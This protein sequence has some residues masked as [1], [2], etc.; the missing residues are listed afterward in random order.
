[1]LDTTDRRWSAMAGTAVVTAMVLL[2]GHPQI[3]Y[4]LVFVGVVWAAALTVRARRAGESAADPPTWSWVRLGDLTAA[5]GTGAAIAAPQLISALA[6]TRDSAIGLG[7]SLAELESPALS[8]R[9]DQ[10][11]QILLGSMRHVNEAEF[12][13]GFES[14]GHVGVAAG[15]VGV[16]GVVVAARDR[17]RRELSIA[18][19]LLAVLGVVWSLGP[20]TP[21]FTV[22]YNWLPGFDLAR[23]SGR[24][25]DIT[26]IA[27]AIGVAWAVDAVAR[28]LPIGPGVPVAITML[29]VALLLGFAGVV[30]LPDR[31]TLAAWLSI[32]TAVFA[33]LAMEVVRGRARPALAVSAL[34]VLLAIE[35]GG[36]TRYSTIDES[37]RST[38]F[39]ALSAGVAGELEGRPGLTMALTDD[40]FG[41]PAYLVAGFR[42]N[43]N[44]LAGVA[45]LDGYDGGVQVTDR[46][47]ALGETTGPGVDPAL[48]LRNK[49]PLPWLPADAARWGVRY[50]V[51]DNDRDAVSLL[52]GWRST[53]LAD[54]EF[55]VWENPAWLG[56]AVGRLDD[57]REVA[58]AFQRRS[59]T[60]LVVTV[61]DP[62]IELS[63]GSSV[64]VTVHRQIA[65]GWRVEVDGR[66]GR[67]IDVDGF[68]LGVDVPADTRTVEF[69]YRP[70]W[71]APSLAVSSIGILALSLCCAFGLR[72][73]AT[74]FKVVR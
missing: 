31:W 60:H 54:R 20:R 46:F 33:V 63:A 8:A 10:L 4:Q 48:P 40:A 56:D 41:D 52:P 30:D 72:G 11:V 66:A 28:E 39:D 61:D 13:G 36:T 14:I 38:A 6:A 27:V 45:S 57:G 25:L 26:T 74:R 12:A 2:A 65:P 42:P 22:A 44:V 67:L 64:R 49:V 5:V 37:R 23:G 18:I 51:V 32:A 62:S 24:W 73:R 29:G 69:F 19:A 53:E 35:F 16:V 58:L 9:P 7:R 47:V 70:G 1:V 68:F 21:V 3:V 34:V 17:A 15:A 59:P 43:T 50:L 55:T 71:V